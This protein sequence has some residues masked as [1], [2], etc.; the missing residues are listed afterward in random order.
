MESIPFTS[1]VRL[2]I[3]IN[4]KVK[5]IAGV[6]RL[7]VVHAEARWIS[8]V[9]K[10][11]PAKLTRYALDVAAGGLDSVSGMSPRWVGEPLK[12]GDVVK[13]RVLRDVQPTTPVHI[14]RTLYGVV[15]GLENR[16]HQTPDL[17]LTSYDEELITAI[18]VLREVRESGSHVFDDLEPIRAPISIKDLLERAKKMQ[19]VVGAWTCEGSVDNGKKA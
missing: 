18:Q 13:I 17:M 12:I 7:G 19:D 14:R 9:G 8:D 11:N 1:P 3:S 4:G 6:D 15:A 2:E 5:A 10:K 16:T